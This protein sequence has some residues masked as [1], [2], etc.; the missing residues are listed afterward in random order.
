[1]MSAAALPMVTRESIV[2]LV[3]NELGFAAAR[4]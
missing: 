4:D 3:W 2:S 1:M